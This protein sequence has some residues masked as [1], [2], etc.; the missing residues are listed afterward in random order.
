[1]P[2]SP[3]RRRRK[4]PHGTAHLRSRASCGLWEQPRPGRHHQLKLGAPGPS[5]DPPPAAGSGR[6]GRA[7][8]VRAALSA[9]AALRTAAAVPPES[10]G[11][12]GPQAP[13]STLAA[14]LGPL[15]LP[16]APLSPALCRTHVCP[17]SGPRV[18]GGAAFPALNPRRSARTS[19][20]PSHA[21]LT[22]TYWYCLIPFLF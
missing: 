10:A 17:Q 9:P 15:R 8:P 13:A 16:P 19:P 7:G 18:Y 14:P 6:A 22:H 20:G 2:R 5:T 12:R 1:M 21:G 11:P 4:R 3:R